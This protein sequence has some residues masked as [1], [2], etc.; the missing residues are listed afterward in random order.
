MAPKRKN[1][2]PTDDLEERLYTCMSHVEAPR[3]A[4][5]RDYLWELAMHTGVDLEIL[6]VTKS[7]LGLRERVYF[8]LTSPEKDRMEQF[9]GILL[10]T[11]EEY[12]RE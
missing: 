10:S 2:P 11:A 9:K 3:W 6:D 12:N 7:C 4:G 1:N 5:V 8:R